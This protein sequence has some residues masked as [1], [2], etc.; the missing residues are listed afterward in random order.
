MATFKLILGV[1]VIVA[2]A[3]LGIKILP[4]FFSNYEFEDFIKEEALHSTYS[5]RSEDDIRNAVIKH[6]HDFDIDLTAKQVHV[7]RTGMNGNGSLTIEA[8]YSVL[9][10]LPGYSTTV[11][12]HPTSK[13]KGVF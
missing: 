12:F 2:V 3:F 1:G 8:D 5:T 6:A 9:I 10:D 7:S 11:E 13:N 4:V